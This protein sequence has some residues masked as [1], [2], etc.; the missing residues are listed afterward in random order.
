MKRKINLKTIIIILLISIVIAIDV[1]IVLFTMI[2]KN[3]VKYE[4]NNILELIEYKAKNTFEYDSKQYI[5]DVINKDVEGKIDTSILGDNNMLVKNPE[6]EN[7]IYNL[8][9]KVED[10]TPPLILGSNTK[11]VYKGDKSDLTNKYLCGDNHDS[12]PKCYIEGSYNTDKIGSYNLK[13]IAEDESGNKSEKNITL[14]VINKTSGSSSSSSTVKRTPLKDYIS[15]YKKEDTKIGIDVSAWQ[16]D[17]NWKKVKDAGVEFAILRIGYGPSS[18]EL[19]LDKWFDNNIKKAKEVNMPLGVYFYSYAKNKEQAKEQAN[20]IVNKLNKQELEIGIA[21]DWEN[22]NS[23][24]SYD[25][26]FK[27]LSD[28]ADTFIDEVEAN[29]YKGYLYSSAYYLNHIW[30]EFDNTWL[31]YYTSNN[32]F[33]KP[34]SIWQLSSSGSVNGISGSVDINVMYN[35]KNKH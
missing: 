14:K 18:G 29:G 2:K 13:Y 35:D 19:K 34:Y 11:T 31:A 12:K 20:W 9:Y 30:R 16:D 1:V 15:K 6:N 22:W 4:N 23:F 33:E 17:I 27:E 24:N 26:S 21:F 8:I 3:R 10:K 32:D 5:K 7:Q 25:V 28:I